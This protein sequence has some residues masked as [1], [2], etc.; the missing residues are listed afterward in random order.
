MEDFTE[1][2]YRRVGFEAGQKVRVRVPFTEGEGYSAEQIAALQRVESAG[3]RNWLVSGG[4]GAKPPKHKVPRRLDGT[5]SGWEDEA[6]AGTLIEALDVVDKGRAHC[7]GVQAHSGVPG[8]VVLDLDKCVADGEL[9]EIAARALAEFR[10]AYAEISPGGNGLRI[11]CR[12][13]V[14][15]GKFK[16][17]GIEVYEVGASKRYVRMTGAEIEGVGGDA[18]ADCQPGIDWALGCIRSSRPDKVSVNADA[19]TNAGSEG[20]VKDGTHSAAEGKQTVEEVFEQLLGYRPTV[21]PAEVLAGMQQQAA[22]KPRGKLAEALRGNLKPW[23]DDASAADFYLVSEAVR[24]GAGSVEDAVEVWSG[25][26]LAKRQKFKRKDYQDRTVALAARDVLVAFSKSP[27][28]ASGANGGRRVPALPAE[29]L[30]SL[31]LSG[32]RVALSARGALQPTAGN[33]IELFRHH[34]L[35]VGRVGFNEL[36]L[37]VE[38]LDSWRLFDRQASDTAGPI[39]D[40]DRTRFGHWLS[41]EFG[42]DIRREALRDGIRS[43][44][45]GAAFNPLQRRLRELGDAWDGVPRIDEWLVRYALVDDDGQREYV[46]AVGRAF[47]V[48]AVARAMRP[49]CKHDTVFSLEGA[50]GAGKSTLFRVLADAVLP[51]LFSDAVQD[52]S[53]PVAVVEATKGKWLVELPEL[54]AVRRASDVESLKAS[55]TRTVE[56]H[57][58]PYAVEPEDIPRRFALVATTNRSEYLA[59]TDGA[60]LRRFWPVRTTATEAHRMPL[61]DLEAVASQLWGEAV[62]LF[63]DGA[64]WWLEESDGL[65]FEQ[66]TGQR[67]ERRELGAFHDELVPV[68]MQWAGAEPGESKSLKEVAKLCGDMRSAEGDQRSLKALSDT[69]RQMGMKN[70]K[71]RTGRMRWRF[72]PDVLMHF[73]RLRL[74]AQRDQAAE[75]A[76]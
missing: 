8:G 45:R 37:R 75:V 72:P 48:G 26:A 57:R 31:S 53:N 14:T 10:D 9:N 24:R 15:P 7:V 33:V 22:A 73:T 60:L 59:D 44:A 68:L 25:T 70:A 64:R 29:F 4:P 71:D 40:D 65:A 74:Q 12:G 19:D 52:M 69:L 1:G 32:D 23:V 43:A 56:T 11:V 39:T 13:V 5:S 35:C 6:S 61:D 76:A 67:A 38:R 30:E 50:G 17:A 20:V 49:G 47:L 34:P 51:G 16:G 42:M 2:T 46:R 27:D 54:S 36:S 55:L 63:D 28:K 66:W 58:E 41:R 3:Y 21:D 18:A 62:R